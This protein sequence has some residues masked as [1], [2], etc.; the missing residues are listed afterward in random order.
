MF[1]DDC[2]AY[3]GIEDYRL[4]F[5]TRWHSILTLALLRS[6]STWTGK[7][8]FSQLSHLLKHHELETTRQTGLYKD[9]PM[10][11]GKILLMEGKVQDV[12][13]LKFAL[14]GLNYHQNGH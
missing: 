6:I 10:K 8:P 14:Q 2:C 4:P 13:L 9:C 5:Y 3:R 7:V 11:L 1:E 12:A